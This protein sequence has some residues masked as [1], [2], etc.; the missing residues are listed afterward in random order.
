MDLSIRA[1]AGEEFIAFSRCVESAFGNQ[2]T[3]EEVADWRGLAEID[4][5]LAAF[6]GDQIVGTA[7]AYTFELSLPG[8]SAVPAAGVTAVGVRPTH[9]RR[10][11]LRALME[12]QLDDVAG[13]PEPVAI[14][15]AAESIIYGRFGYGA[16]TSVVEV[17][18]DT[19]YGAFAGAPVDDGRMQFV[20]PEDVGSIIPALHDQARRDQPG[21]INRTAAWWDLAARDPDWRHPG[22]ARLFWAVHLGAAG[23]PDGFVSYRV[24]QGWSDDL[25]DSKVEVV[26][27][28]GLEPAVEVAL[29]RYVLDLDLVSRVVAARPP[30]EAVRWRLADPRRM[31]TTSMTDGIWVRLLDVP[32][33]LAARRYSIDTELIF[34]VADPFRPSSGGRYLLRAGPDGAECARTKRSADISLGVA[35]LGSSYLGQSRFTLL[36][37][38]GRAVEHTPGALRRADLAFSGFPPPHCRTG[39]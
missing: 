25:P 14:L 35:E 17:S 3:A 36:A 9:R 24:G 16:A 26:D 23:Q 13:G 33:A 21:D 6:E 7:G 4:R 8:G 20:E 18:I 2:A 1:V 31:R 30:E 5:T 19:R 22:K 10:G 27:L 37:G 11:L 29:W 12:R 39:F 28:I 32:A 38:A 15:L 34:D